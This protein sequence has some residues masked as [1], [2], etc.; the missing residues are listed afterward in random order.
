MPKVSE[1]NFT[2]TSIE[3]PSPE[4]GPAVDPVPQIEHGQVTLTLTPGPGVSRFPLS[5]TARD[6]IT[7]DGAPWAIQEYV[8]E[9]VPVAGCHVVPP[10][11][12]TSTPATTPPPVSLAVP[13]TVTTVPSG[14]VDPAVGEVIVDVGGVVSVD[15][16]AATSPASSVAGWAP[17][18]ASRFTVACC[19]V[20]SA[21]RPVGLPLSS[22]HD[23]C[24]VPAPNTS[25][26]LEARYSVR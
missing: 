8:H 17:M 16:D 26:P 21:A 25:A 9:V 23:H 19:I 12:D 5:S 1:V 3:D 7:V 14:V 15:A 6:L 22:P 11:V 20:G 13:V 18:S 10:S 2:P 24:T 4:S